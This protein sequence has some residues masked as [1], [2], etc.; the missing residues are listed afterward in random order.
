MS[1]LCDD[2]GIKPVPLKDSAKY[3]SAACRRNSKNKR[4]RLYRSE[5]RYRTPVVFQEIE[6]R[7]CG[8][9]FIPHCHHQ[10]FCSRLCKVPVPTPPRTKAN[11]RWY[12]IKS[13]Y[14]MTRDEWEALFDSQG[15]RCAACRTDT[16]APTWAVDHNHMTGEWRAILCNRCNTAFGFMRENTDAIRGLLEYSIRVE[17]KTQ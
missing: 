13:Y 7:T 6:C 3:C 5:G 10:K 11:H 8:N 2:C 1:V 16:P 17:A 15:R 12:Q 9:S 14:G 4:R